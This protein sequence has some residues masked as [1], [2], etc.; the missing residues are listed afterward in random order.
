MYV[1]ASKRFVVFFYFYCFIYLEKYAFIRS[2]TFF[3][4][5]LNCEETQL[6]LRVFVLW[7]LDIFCLSLGVLLVYFCWIFFF[8]NSKRSRSYF[9][10][11]YSNRLIIYLVVELPT[12]A[13]S[14]NSI[15]CPFSAIFRLY[16][17]HYIYIRIYR[18]RSV[19]H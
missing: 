8:R 12:V 16:Q 4:K 7:K 9:I 1:N 3:R 10:G 11:R 19:L 14:K 6:C 18:S 15:D 5:K 2:V 17:F 13:H